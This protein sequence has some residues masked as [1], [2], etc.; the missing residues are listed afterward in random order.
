M[1]FQ[2]AGMTLSNPVSS[3]RIVHAQENA[4]STSQA[5]VTKA[6]INDGAPERMMREQSHQTYDTERENGAA[7]KLGADLEC[8]RRARKNQQRDG[9]QDDDLPGLQIPVHQGGWI[10]EATVAKKRH[11]NS[12]DHRSGCDVPN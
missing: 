1:T 5:A 10:I 11:E 7:R 8:E 3:R 12:R 9:P 2:V 6:R 4:F